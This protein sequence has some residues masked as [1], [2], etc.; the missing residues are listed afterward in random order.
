[1]IPMSLLWCGFAVFWE[2]MAFGK[3]SPLFFRLWGLPFVLAG[4]YMV[5]GRFIV[6]ARTRARTFY[7]VTNERIIILGGLFSRQTKSMQLATLSDISLTERAAGSGTISFGPQHPRA[8]SLPAGW[9]GA[10]PYAAPA[11]EM[12]DRAKEVYD[13]IWQTQKAAK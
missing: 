4:L 1:M 12:I 2:T 5:F 6:D 11:F 8:R 10:G 9:P 13:L 3:K 7:G